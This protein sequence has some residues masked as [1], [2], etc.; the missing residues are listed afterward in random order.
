VINSGEKLVLAGRLDGS[1]RWPPSQ[2]GEADQCEKSYGND[3]N[4]GASDRFAFE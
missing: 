3:R 2:G 1:N 4:C